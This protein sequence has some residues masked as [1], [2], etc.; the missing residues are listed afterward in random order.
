MHGLDV[1]PHQF[2]YIQTFAALMLAL[3]QAL[4][5]ESSLVSSFALN[6]YIQLARRPQ[7]RDPN[8]LSPELGARTTQSQSEKP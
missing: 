2:A 4:H 8:M 6:A 1:S 3:N 5:F 7:Y